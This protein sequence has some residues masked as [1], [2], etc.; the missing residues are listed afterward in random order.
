MTEKE[1]VLAATKQFICGFCTCRECINLY[2]CQACEA[3]HQITEDP[4]NVKKVKEYVTQ[5]YGGA[6]D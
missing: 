5:L 6:H 4:E 1:M 3:W 2:G